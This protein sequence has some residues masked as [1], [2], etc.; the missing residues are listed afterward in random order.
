MSQ[1]RDD[2]HLDF[3]HVLLDHDG[4]GEH[5]SLDLS[6]TRLEDRMTSLGRSTSH[7]FVSLQK[8]E[9]STKNNE[10]DNTD[11][12]DFASFHG[13]KTIREVI[14]D[15]GKLYP[16]GEEYAQPMDGKRRV[17]YHDGIAHI[18][19][20]EGQASTEPGVHLS[21]MVPEK[22][23]LDIRLD[24]GGD[25][26]VPGKI[27]GDV[28]LSTSDGAINVKKLRGHKVNLEA[29]GDH[30]LIY[31]TDLLEAQTL[32]MKTSGR[33]RAKQL[34]GSSIDVRLSPTDF[35][36]PSF[37]ALDPDDDTALIDVSSIYV[38]GEGG[39]TLAV[40]SAKP[41]KKAIRLKT[42]HGPIRTSVDGVYQPKMVDPNTGEIQPLVEL[43]GVNGN[44]EL[45]TND[46]IVND[47]SEWKSCRVHV[48]SLSPDTVSL[49]SAD[50]GDIALTID[51]KVEADL[52][53]LST[54]CTDCVEEA[55]AML[56]EEED[57]ELAI[58]VLKNIPPSPNESI[59]FGSEPTISIETKAFTERPGGNYQA[60][61]IHYVDG[62]VKD[63]SAEPPS[64][65]DRKVRGDIT[66]MGKINL[67][68]AA[69]QALHAFGE[70]SNYAEEFPRPLVAVIGTSQ[71][72]VETVSWLG[73]I[74]RRYGLD[75]EGRE[76]GR[77]AS[78]KGRSL[79]PQPNSEK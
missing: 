55:T 76:A 61:H 49:L 31:A 30:G 78:R 27:E 63:N 19:G 62:W 54:T 50:A 40:E 48:D 13:S 58:S 34:H 67:S 25:I 9:A 57:G 21:I 11:S 79:Q 28:E 39:A 68:S 37:D 72:K 14:T 1:W 36:R 6:V 52:R 46:T 33:V 56:A 70:K 65:F 41:Q 77:T 4:K 45:F 7:L 43:G 59:P 60:S 53:L 18:T 16:D 38:A 15:D 29:F 64:R 5:D 3:E 47:T 2:G 22:V 8:A 10:N 24:Q 12:L 26:N 35:S 20:D 66:A 51:R 17:E 44:F 23:N 69:D 73:A 32:S 75:E 42:N 71:V 74:A